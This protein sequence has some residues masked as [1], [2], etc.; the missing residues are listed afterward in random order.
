M[1]NAIVNRVAIIQ[2]NYIPWKGYFDIIHDVDLFIFYDDVQFTTRDWR[3]RNKIKT[4]NGTTWLTVPVGSRVDRLICEVQIADQNWQQK[5]WRS[6]SQAYA[7]APFF[8]K[9]RAFFSAV[10]LG[11][12]WTRLSELNVYLTK[13]IATDFLGID[14]EFRDSREFS[15]QGSKD[16]RLLDILKK[17][18]AQ[19][20]VSGPSAK[21]YI[22]E[23]AFAEAG[24]QLI[25]KDYSGYP[26]Y[27]QLHPPFEHAVSIIDLLFNVGPDAPH[28]IW[29]WRG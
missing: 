8:A 23:S 28:Y 27:P 18:G 16:A 12:N 11:Q 13:R 20:Y 29:G 19:T 10:F 24:I 1:Q 21:D 15:P 26:E 7:R 3:S 22:D 6:I 5:H 17:V 9:Y 4:A 25:W 14:V 2:S